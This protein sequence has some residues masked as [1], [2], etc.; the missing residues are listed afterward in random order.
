[1]TAHELLRQLS[2]QQ[3]STK[4][5]APPSG[6]HKYWKVL[7]ADSDAE[8]R[9]RISAV[10]SPL[11]I[12]K[13]SVECYQASSASELRE[14]LQTHQQFAVILL[15]TGLA[16]D[17][18]TQLLKQIRDEFGLK[19][20]RI[21][22]RTDEVAA[23]PHLA[24][25]QA[26]DIDD[27]R[28][29]AELTPERILTTFTSSL[30][31]FEQMQA[32]SASKRGLDIIARASIELMGM[33]GLQS[34]ASGVLTQLAGLLGIKAEGMVCTE[35][36]LDDGGTDVIVI[37]AAGRFTHL[38][39]KSLSSTSEQVS[40]TALLNCLHDGHHRFNDH[41]TVL[42]FAGKASRN[43]AAYLVT[44]GPLE[45]I[46]RRLIEVF[47]SNISVGMDNVSLFSR[48]H[49]YAY[50][51][52]LLGLPN[53]TKFVGMISERLAQPHAANT[54]LALVD[55]DNFAETNDALGH[56]FGDRLLQAVCARLSGL[57]GD[58]CVLARVSGDAFGILG[59]EDIVN[60]DVL[61]PAFRQPFV[62]SENRLMVSVTI[63]LVRLS[64]SSTTGTEALKDASIA[65]KRTKKLRRGNYAYFT[66][67]MGDEIRER[68]QLL[69]SLRHAFNNDQLSLHYQPQIDLNSGKPIGF[70]ALM[71]WQ[72]PN[73]RLIPPS[74][75]IPLAEHSGL[76][77]NLGEW[78]L[79]L[80]CQQLA[81]LNRQGHHHLR[82]AVN[83]SVV[84]FHHPKFITML[85]E[86]LANSGITPNCLEL[87]ITESMAMEEPEFIMRT[88]D[89][90]KETG[91]SISVDD[92]GT[93]FS[94]LSYLQRLNVDRLKIDRSFISEMTD[95]LRSSRIAEMILQL[96]Q[97]LN[98]VTLA[99]GVEDELQAG[100]LS[101][102]GCMEA[103]G[104]LFGRPMPPHALQ[105]WLENYQAPQY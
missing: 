85:R 81:E 79:N 26:L 83:V 33:H 42:Y 56:Q 8:L 51:D 74:R 90:V 77:I 19:D 75:F 65:L 25:I 36:M 86:A 103:Q 48:L 14:A 5:T 94:S 84:Q 68:V 12:L 6:E 1:M 11:T 55:I 29:S 34:F 28:T 41:S 40:R 76:I 18:S 60:P 13:H 23:C 7:I 72:L 97:N 99:E 91:V 4:D 88:L 21:I 9:E 37:A 20:A 44:Q 62:I 63:G 15:H 27:F 30:R 98:L 57:L 52:Q 67:E 92:F 70:E 58:R 3:D 89:A 49:E 43:M 93:G 80:A 45:D 2:S 82:M 16:D 78:A 54:I 73:N 64:E 22:L 46:D 47:C 101:Q 10:L 39:G 100:V 87:E 66:R 104:Y 32:A 59:P 105:T 35:D 31:T 95:P 24:Q 96:G 69:N 53:R 17:C 102:L 61:L 50:Y 71:R 38:I